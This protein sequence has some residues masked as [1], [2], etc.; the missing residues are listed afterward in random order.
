[1]VVRS[2]V[3]VLSVLVLGACRTE[4]VPP[5]APADVDEVAPAPDEPHAL[6]V[7]HAWDDRRSAA[8]GQGDVA[9]L[10]DLYVPRSRAGRRDAEILRQYAERDL[11]VRH[12]RVQVLR[13]DAR[14]DGPRLVE[15]A[16]REKVSGTVRGRGTRWA[17]PYDRADSH[18][19]V[20]VRRHG[21]W[22]LL[23]ATRP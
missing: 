15:V 13:F 21:S 16:V 6:R 19:L 22:R 14:R 9:A 5:V 8:Y 4:P 11:V 2:V 7:L 12:L 18:V 17:L 23:S 20:L 3:V 10:R 1:M